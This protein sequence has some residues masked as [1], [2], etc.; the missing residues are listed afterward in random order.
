MEAMTHTKNAPNFRIV[1]CCGNCLYYNKIN[2][3]KT[4][5]FCDKYP[6]NSPPPVFNDVSDLFSHWIY[7]CD[8]WKGRH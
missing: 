3:I 2:A 7:V 8:N 4:P 5:D 6:E 1:R